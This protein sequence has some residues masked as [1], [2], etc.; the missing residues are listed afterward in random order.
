MKRLALPL[1]L[2][3]ALLATSIQCVAQCAGAA[4]SAQ[5]Q[6][7]CHGSAPADDSVPCHGP[8]A[9][10]AKLTETSVH[11]DLDSVVL[12]FTDD[13]RIPMLAEQVLAE[14]PASRTLT[15]QRSV[16]VLRL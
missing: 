2:L 13:L 4:D 11:F 12:F 7:D 5:E 16:T 6:S 1:I 3:L 15:A 8:A 14:T 10:A 9:A